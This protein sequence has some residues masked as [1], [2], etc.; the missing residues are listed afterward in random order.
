L[1]RISSQVT[2]IQAQALCA[3]PAQSRRSSAEGGLPNRLR[4]L[5]AELPEVNTL[6][7]ELQNFQVSISESGFDSYNARSGAHDDMV[8]SV[9][10][11]LWLGHKYQPW[12]VNYGIF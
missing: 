2:A 6:I 8:L 11:A 10:M 9:A 4:L 12:S 7:H 3:F 5:A 1:E